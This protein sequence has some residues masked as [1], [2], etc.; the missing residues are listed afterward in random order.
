MVAAASAS[1]LTMIQLAGANAGPD[2]NR[3]LDIRNSLSAA[4]VPPPGE[5]QRRCQDLPPPHPTSCAAHRVLQSP[6]RRVIRALAYPD[7]ARSRPPRHGEPA[8][9]RP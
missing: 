8:G 6:P 3:S 1:P 5:L 2:D 7:A 9:L 4:A